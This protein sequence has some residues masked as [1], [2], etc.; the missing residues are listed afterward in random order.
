MDDERLIGLAQIIGLLTK[1]TAGLT[2][3]MW[4]DG[5]LTLENSAEYAAILKELA[6]LYEHGDEKTAA[7]LLTASNLIQRQNQ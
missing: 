3:R 6:L 5:L 7:E 2:L 4:K 1:L